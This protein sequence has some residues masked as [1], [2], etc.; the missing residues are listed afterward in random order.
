MKP[1][2]KLEAAKGGM[3]PLPTRI[4]PQVLP[5]ASAHLYCA[6]RQGVL[7]IFHTPIHT[8]LNPWAD[9]RAYARNLPVRIHF[10]SGDI[11]ANLHSMLTLAMQ[12]GA[13]LHLV[14]TL[15]ALVAR[16]AHLSSAVRGVLST[17]HT[18]CTHLFARLH[19]RSEVAHWPCPY[20]RS[21]AKNNVLPSTCPAYKG[22]T[23]FGTTAAA[24]ATTTRRGGQRSFQG[25]R[26]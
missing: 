4:L 13:F 16:I 24:T 1:M 18:E 8:K 14:V 9:L 15:T 3:D 7:F 6:A 21:D 2:R 19:V 23:Q 11:S 20:V 17:L 10:L 25:R 26:T 5:C 22:L 12:S